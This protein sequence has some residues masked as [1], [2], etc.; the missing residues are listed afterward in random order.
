MKEESNARVILA[1][2]TIPSTKV[3]PHDMTKTM[4]NGSFHLL[5]DFH[6]HLLFSVYKEDKKSSNPNDDWVLGGWFFFWLIKACKSSFFFF[7]FLPIDTSGDGV[8]AT[9]DGVP[10]LPGFP[11]RSTAFSRVVV[12]PLT[13]VGCRQA[14]QVVRTWLRHRREAGVF[15]L[16]EASIEWTLTVQLTPATNNAPQ[17]AQHRRWTASANV[18]LAWSAVFWNWCR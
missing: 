6:Y 13:T 4:Y 17:R 11:G 3:N 7:D 16:F 8:V 1:F 2:L 18:T 15:L 9:V 5:Y 10:S 14:W 12:E